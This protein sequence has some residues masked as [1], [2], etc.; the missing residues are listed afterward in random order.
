[1]G[2]AQRM[3][4]AILKVRN[5]RSMQ[6][7]IRINNFRGALCCSGCTFTLNLDKLPAC[8]EGSLKKRRVFFGQ[9]TQIWV[10]GVGWSQSFKNTFHQK[11]RIFQIAPYIFPFLGQSVIVAI[12][13][14]EENPVGGKKIIM[15][16]SE[17]ML[18][19]IFPNLRFI[20]IN[21]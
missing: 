6:R 13:Y 20:S 17:N 7:F 15:N 11:M 3:K 14:T 4:N 19:S 1:M 18:N 5:I 2:F 12:C 16:K 21:H 8:A 10:G 9:L